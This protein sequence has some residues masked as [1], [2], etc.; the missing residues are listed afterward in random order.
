M[1]MSEIKISFVN[2]PVVWELETIEVAG[3]V[4]VVCAVITCDEPL[5]RLHF[6]NHSVLVYPVTRIASLSPNNRVILLSFFCIFR[7][8][9]LVE[10]VF[11]ELLDHVALVYTIIDKV[12]SVFVVWLLYTNYA[13]QKVANAF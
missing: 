13:R 2:I 10:H 8:K 7:I 9:W 5:A 11:S 4:F 1:Q 3:E 6:R 12:V